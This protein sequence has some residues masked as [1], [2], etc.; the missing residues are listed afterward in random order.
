MKNYKKKSI[1]CVILARGG[2]KG[3]PKKNIF[4]LNNHPLISYTIEAAKKSKFIDKIIVST[5]NLQ[6]AQI[7]KK[8]GAEVP[9]LRPKKLATDKTPSVDALN[10]AVKKTEQIFNLISFF[11]NIQ[12]NF[13]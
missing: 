10:H 9:F 5:D 13:T 1:L 12:S 2:S 7:A 6:I 4:I 11:F 3:I 8:Y